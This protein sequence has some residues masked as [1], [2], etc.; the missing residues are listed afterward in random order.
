MRT[1]LNVLRQ[2]EHCS[3]SM[4]L[5]PSQRIRTMSLW[6]SCLSNGVVFVLRV[7]VTGF[8]IWGCLKFYRLSWTQWSCIG[9]GRGSAYN[10][11]WIAYVLLIRTVVLLILCRGYKRCFIRSNVLW[12]IWLQC[13]AQIFDQSCGLAARHSL[14]LSLQDLLCNWPDYLARCMAFEVLSVCQNVVRRTCQI[15]DRVGEEGDGGEES[16]KEKIRC[17]AEK[18]KGS[19]R[20]SPAGTISLSAKW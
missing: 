11:C 1:P 17:R 3:F 6:F 16:K 20:H 18:K 8:Y 13:C 4:S 2:Q 19:R 15:Q 10:W 12:T 5:Y 14:L 7:S 9:S